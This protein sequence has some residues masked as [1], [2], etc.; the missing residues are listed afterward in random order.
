MEATMSLFFYVLQVVILTTPQL[1]VEGVKKKIHKLKPY[2]AQDLLYS[3]LGDYPNN[4]DLLDLSS[5]YFLKS[6][7]ITAASISYKMIKLHPD[8]Y[9]GYLN[10]AKALIKIGKRGLALFYLI[11]SVRLSPYCDECQYLL[12][13]EYINQK[14]VKRAL[15]HLKMAA[16]ANP[17]SI[18]VYAKLS[19]LTKDSS[20]LYALAY[21]LYSKKQYKKAIKV[22]NLAQ[23]IKLT[24]EILSLKGEIYDKLKKHFL[25][26]KTYKLC[27]KRFKLPEAAYNTANELVKIKKYSRAI[28]YYNIAIKKGYPLKKALY[29]KAMTYMKMR[30]Y[31]LS[32]KLLKQLSKMYPSVKVYNNLANAY[33]RMGRINSAIKYYQ[34]ALKLNPTDLDVIHNLV[35]A[36]RRKG[37]WVYVEYY[38]NM[39]RALKR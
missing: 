3:L 5:K 30:K 35:I 25:S 4:Y 6:D 17:T 34:K 7:P 26:Y 20:W 16:I 15:I 21:H 14:N 32:A 27:Y 11:E 31:K 29:N 36:Y 10:M 13:N 38:K 22:L 24:P 12:A 37:D 28:K 2:Q 33:L 39:L 8:Y 19:K 1:D 9:K 23:K 18:P